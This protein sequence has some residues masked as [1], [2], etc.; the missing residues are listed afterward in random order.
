[1]KK[2]IEKRGNWTDKPCFYASVTDGGRTALLLGPFRTEVK[3]RRWAYYDAEDGGSELNLKLKKE[4]ECDP[5]SCWYSYGMVKMANGYR[6][7]IFN[8]QFGI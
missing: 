6:E 2:E 3:C 7:G 5:K 8:K 1:M 4:C